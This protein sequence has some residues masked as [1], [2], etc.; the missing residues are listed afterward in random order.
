MITFD[1]KREDFIDIIEAYRQRK[2]VE[3]LHLIK[4]L[5]GR[6]DYE[7]PKKEED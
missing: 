1:V 4:K 7:E 6:T 3:E 5:L 2:Y